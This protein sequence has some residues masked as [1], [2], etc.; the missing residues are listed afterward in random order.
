MTKLKSL[1]V[2]CIRR[3]QLIPYQ[4]F[5]LGI[6]FLAFVAGAGSLVLVYRQVE[7]LAD[8]SKRQTDA[9]VLQTKALELQTEALKLQT[10]A[11]NLEASRTL[12][13]IW[14]PIDEI[15]IRRPDLWPYFNKNVDP[16]PNSEKYISATAVAEL[17]LDSFDVFF[18]KDGPAGPSMPAAEPTKRPTSDKFMGDMFSTSPLLCRRLSDVRGWYSE[19]LFE[20]S[21]AFC[22]KP[23]AAQRKE[24]V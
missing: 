24:P 13:Q 2:N 3:E 16:K 14:T 18:L 8:Q 23:S 20:F 17:I 12:A 9:L 4:L 19:K 21:K 7:N 11:A 22:N 6:L 10:A 15:F 1:I 5:H